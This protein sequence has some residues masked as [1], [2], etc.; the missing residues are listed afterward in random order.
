LRN[1]EAMRGPRCQFRV[2]PFSAWAVAGHA[3]RGLDCPNGSAPL[4]Y[5]WGLYGA[6]LIVLASLFSLVFG[7]LSLLDGLGP[8][9]QGSRAIFALLI[10]PL[11]A[12]LLYPV[13]RHSEYRLEERSSSRQ[14]DLPRTARPG[15]V[16]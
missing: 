11:A 6:L 1:L 14:Q 16:G 5:G 13:W 10:V 15:V 7:V 8:D 2:I 12:A 3:V 4:R 9:A